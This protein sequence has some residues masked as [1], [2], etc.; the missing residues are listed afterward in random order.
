MLKINLGCGWRDF[1]E[2]WVHID[3]G[4]Y[5]HIESKDICNLPYEDGSVDLIYASHVIEYFDRDE[6][7]VLL[8]NWQS[9]LKK[10]GIL[11]LAVPDFSSMSALY[12]D[13]VFSLDSFLGPLYGK[14]KMQENLIYHKTVYDYDSLER[15]LHASGYNEVAT[16]D[17]RKTD[18]S[19]FDDHSQAYVPHMD[20]EN[21][22]LISLNVEAVK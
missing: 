3:G 18:H 5:D 10:G 4:D 13:G 7:Q 1:G 22:T 17:W 2:D 9:K 16:W 20:K 11:R 15:L 14:M 19:H 21:G 12:Q 8:N 6:V